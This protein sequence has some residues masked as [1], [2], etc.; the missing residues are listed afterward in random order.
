MAGPYAQK[1]DFIKMLE[2]TPVLPAP[3]AYA[4]REAAVQYVRR[5]LEREAHQNTTVRAFLSMLDSN[6]RIPI[7]EG[8]CLAVRELTASVAR[9]QCELTKELQDAP[10]D[11]KQIVA[12]TVVVMGADGKLGT[13]PKT[14]D[15]AAFDLAQGQ[16]L[17][18]DG[19]R[20]VL[21]QDFD[22]WRYARECVEATRPKMQYDSRIKAEEEA[23]EWFHKAMMCGFD[24]GQRRAGVAKDPYLFNEAGKPRTPADIQAHRERMERLAH[25]KAADARHKATTEKSR[26]CEVARMRRP[27]MQQRDHR[28]VRTPVHSLCLPKGTAAAM[29]T[30]QQ[31]ENDAP[32][33]GER[34]ASMTVTHNAQASFTDDPGPDR[35]EVPA[36]AED[37]DRVGKVNGLAMNIAGRWYEAGTLLWTGMNCPEE[38]EQLLG[39]LDVKPGGWNDDPA[40][41][42]YE[43]W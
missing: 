6:R 23:F 11:P 42:R 17:H 7:A 20:P 13:R 25:A 36:C 1:S 32:P 29:E 39:I 34:S 12:Q 24:E 18:R 8:L 3:S 22:A 9:L 40:N 15:D 19:E 35:L 4:D 16:F 21:E 14:R 37:H 33:L 2:D 41:P 43:N 38:G 26:E 30:L 31:L 10:R 27:E 5:Y 28:D